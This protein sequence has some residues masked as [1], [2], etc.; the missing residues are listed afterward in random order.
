M[1]RQS[2]K[3]WIALGISRATWYR[4]SKPTTWSKRITVAE[5]AAN[6]GAPSLRSHQRIM[7]VLDSPLLP[8]LVAG[9]LKPGQADKLLSSPRRLQQFL[10]EVEREVERL[11]ASGDEHEHIA[12]VLAEWLPD[13]KR[14]AVVEELHCNGATAPKAAG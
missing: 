10:E 14:Q 2:E 9:I 4:H 6:L 13:A 1:R 8:F 5:E 11:R 3:P 7:R 12:A